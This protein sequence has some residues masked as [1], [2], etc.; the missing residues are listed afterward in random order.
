MLMCRQPLSLER[1]APLV[2]LPVLL[3]VLRLLR[4]R[5][6]HRRRHRRLLSLIQDPDQLI[7]LPVSHG[8]CLTIGRSTS[9]P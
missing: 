7:G 9:Q 3:A 5:L 8:P 4:Q 6:R 2:A 1:L